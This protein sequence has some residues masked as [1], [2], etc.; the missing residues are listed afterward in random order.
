MK[1]FLDYFQLRGLE[2]DSV[3]KQIFDG[4]RKKLDLLVDAQELEVFVRSPPPLFPPLLLLLWCSQDLEFDQ[5]RDL[6]N[7]FL[8]NLLL[9]LPPLDSHSEHS[10]H[11]FSSSLSLS[12]QSFHLYSFSSFS[13][14]R[15]KLLHLGSL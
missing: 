2:E 7:S 10:H 12:I 9:L 13:L 15:T 8:P 14:S 3:E 5:S 4:G 6:D 1:G 11:S